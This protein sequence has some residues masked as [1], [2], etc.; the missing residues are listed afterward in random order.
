MNLITG[1]S[2]SLLKSGIYNNESGPDFFNGEVIIDGLRWRGNIELH[3]KSSDWYMHKHHYDKAYDN[4]ILHVVYKYDTPVYINGRLLPTLE[5]AGYID[6]FHFSNFKVY[7]NI[8]SD[9]VCSNLIDKIESIYIQK[10]KD[11]A[12]INRLDKKNNLKII[13]NEI[14][15]DQIMYFYFANSFGMKVNS[16]PF[17]QITHH[18][19]LKV[20]KRENSENINVLLKGISGFI[21]DFDSEHQN[22]YNTE[23][24]L[25]EFLRKKYNLSQIDQFQWKKKGLR[26][27]G[28]PEIRLIQFSEFVQLFDFNTELFSKSPLDIIY[29]IKTVLD[30]EGTD[31]NIPK[32]SDRTKDLIIINGL[33]PFMWWYGNQKKDILLREK[34]IEVLKNIKSESNY[35]INKWLK[36][37]LDCKKAFDSQSL[38]E[39]YNEFCS[40][41][42][43]LSCVVGNKILSK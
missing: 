14:E 32:I 16:I 26:P 2:F 4:V 11:K 27:S 3:V 41:K 37:G 33:V 18:L 21:S 28:F 39:I 35:I 15:Y 20:L 34:A 13:D 9:I 6:E 1:E 12:I 31:K 36:V 29:R 30:F 5:L 25:W 42:Q 22:L 8:S 10:M 38:L 7:S 19:P 43:C 40:K 23:T 24:K 17:Q